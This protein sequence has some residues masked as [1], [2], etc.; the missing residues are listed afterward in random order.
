MKESWIQVSTTPQTR[1]IGGGFWCLHFFS[2]FLSFFV[3]FMDGGGGGSN[4]LTWCSTPSQPV[5]LC[6]GERVGVGSSIVGSKYKEHRRIQKEEQF[7]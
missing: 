1:E 3:C 2:L 5:R 6:Q 4:L 7:G